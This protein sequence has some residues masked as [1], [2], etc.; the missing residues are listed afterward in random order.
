METEEKIVYSILEVVNKGIHSDDNK[1]DERVIRALIKPYRATILSKASMNGYLV[2]DECFQSLGALKYTR[3]NGRNFST[4]IPKILRFKDNF[5][6]YLKIDGEE[7]SFIDSE[8]FFLSSKNIISK[9]LPKAKIEGSLATIYIGEGLTS[10]G[11][12]H[13]KKNN[14]IESLDNSAKQNNFLHIN[15]ETM[16]ILDDTDLGVGYDWTESP[17]PM[18]SELIAEMKLMILAKEF[19]IIAQTNPDKTTDG[20][21]KGSAGASQ[22][23]EER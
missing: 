9:R 18:P 17:Y 12:N 16:A 8:S 21:D 10:G 23:Q 6:L 19:N 15:V 20:N 13:P 3:T 14:L 22:T 11:V 1:I 5:G 2:A 4:V 7:F